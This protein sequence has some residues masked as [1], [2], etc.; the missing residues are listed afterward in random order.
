[1]A[2]HWKIEKD[3]NVVFSGDGETLTYDFPNN[4]GSTNI[5]YKVYI[6][7]ES[8]FSSV[9]DYVV[10]PCGASN[11][12][13]DLTITQ[14]SE[15]TFPSTGGT[16][17]IGQIANSHTV[18]IYMQPSW[19]DNL[20]TDASGN[21]Y[22]TAKANTSTTPYTSTTLSFMVDGT[23]CNGKTV[24][25]SQEAA[26]A[27]VC[28]YISGVTATSVVFDSS[29]GTVNVGPCN[30]TETYTVGK[31][32]TSFP[33]SNAW[34][35]VEKKTGTFN[36]KYVQLS[37]STYN[38]ENP[39]NCTVRLTVDGNTCDKVISVVQRGTGASCDCYAVIL[40]ETSVTLPWSGGTAEV[41]SFL[42]PDGVACLLAPYMESG[43]ACDD[44]NRYRVDIINGN[45]LVATAKRN[46]YTSITTSCPIKFKVNG[47]SCD[48]PSLTITQEAAPCCTFDLNIKVVNNR[49]TPIRFDYIEFYD[50]VST[51]VVTIPLS[52]TYTISASA[53]ETFSDE[54]IYL[55]GFDINSSHDCPTTCTNYF[56][57]HVDTVKLRPED[58]SHET[59]TVTLVGYQNLVPS[60][61]CEIIVN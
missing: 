6:R 59:I 2:K 42:A 48:S 61:T 11:P 22:I 29:G 3:N 45:T 9:T 21:I 13:D 15:Y 30:K 32:S 35:Y 7:D 12:C 37:A 57:R 5:T 49:T 51:H 38:G 60:L 16:K 34:V 20:S 31:V 4:T 26:E 17:N 50:M 54:D 40:N 39:R 44:D 18:T 58:T 25:V 52:K 56:N 10:I 27:S 55:N 53:T 23:L 43:A 19:I 28:E 33:H 46:K 1:M 36:T 41:G 14:T 47:T 8:G 24:T